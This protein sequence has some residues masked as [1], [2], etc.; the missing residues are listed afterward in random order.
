MLAVA[1]VLVSTL[2]WVDIYFD[3]IDKA[4]IWHRRLAITGIVLV[5]PHI[6][7][8]HGRGQPPAGQARPVWW[9]RWAW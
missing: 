3:G 6:L 7:M 5:L 8:S 2:P 1:I 4:A 9:R